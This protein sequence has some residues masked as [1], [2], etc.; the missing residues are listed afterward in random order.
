MAFHVVLLFSGTGGAKCTYITSSSKQTGSSD[1]P[2]PIT[3][4]K[5]ENGIYVKKKAYLANFERIF[6]KFQSAAML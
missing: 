6:E 4:S 1:Q 3:F 5:N 2:I